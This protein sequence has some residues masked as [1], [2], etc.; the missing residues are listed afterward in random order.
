MITAP[1]L[2]PA[3]PPQPHPLRVNSDVGSAVHDDQPP[4]L[5]VG[6]LQSWYSM[7]RALLECVSGCTC[8]AAELE[9]FQPTRKTTE[10]TTG[11][12]PISPHPNCRVR[13]TV[14]NNTPNGTPRFKVTS[15]AVSAQDGIL[16]NTY[17]SVWPG[18]R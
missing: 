4:V 9:G 2:Q 1:A 14:A 12:F 16:N 6:W 17:A 11:R 13:F 15:L 10:V 3:A 7:G 18:A 5:V 8:S